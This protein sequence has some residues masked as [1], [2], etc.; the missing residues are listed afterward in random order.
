MTT[1]LAAGSPDAR[2]AGNLPA[3]VSS[4]IGRRQDLAEVKAALERSRLVTLCGVGGVG[5][6]RLALRTAADLGGRFADGVWLVELSALREPGPLARAVGDALRLPGGYSGDPLDLLADHLA[7]RHLLLVLDTCEH[8]IDACATLAEVLAR[9]APRLRI[10]V[11]SREPLDVIGEHTIMVSPLPAPAPAPEDAPTDAGADAGTDTGTGDSDGE[12]DGDAMRLF[13]ERAAAMKPGFALTPGNRRAVARLCHRLDGIPLAIELAA[14]RLRVMS[15]EQLD[16]RLDDRFRLLGTARTS[17]YRHQ[18]LH[19]AIAW[20]HELCTTAEQALWARLSVFPGDFDL[21]AAEHVCADAPVPPAD[22][23]PDGTVPDGTVPDATVL[24]PTA[25]DPTVPAHDLLDVLTRL[26]EKSVV[27]Y[28]RTR[29]RYRMLDT[30][31]EFGAELLE[32]SGGRDGHARRHHRHYAALS[33][34]AAEARLSGAQLGWARRLRAEVPNLRAA[35]EWT[36]NTP[37]EASSGLRLAA[38]LRHYWYSTGQFNEGRDWCQRVLAATTGVTAER[39]WTAYGVGLFAVLQGDLADAGPLLAEAAEA[40]GTLGDADLWAHAVHERGRS[41]FYAGDIEKALGCYRE[42]QAI[43]ERD[44]HRDPDALTIYTDLG[45][46]LAL[47]GDLDGALRACEQGL[48]ACEATGEQWARA[49]ALWMRG[50]TH[51]LGGAIDAAARDARESLLIVEAFND[52]V[53]ATM[54]L[55]LLMV[56][57]V[58]RDEYER[59]AVLAGA[60]AGMWQALRAPIQRGPHYAGLRDAG[61]DAARAALGDERLRTAQDA[62]RALPVGEAIALALDPA[63][64][65]DLP[66]PPGSAVTV[67]TRRERQVAELVAE[68]LSNREIAERLIIAKRTVDSHVEHILAKL[69]VSS[70][71]QVATRTGRPART[72]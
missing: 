68:G 31:R 5:K 44:G 36:L 64:A 16:Q 66:P 17:Q 38:S 52:Q 20:S 34:R 35:L 54:C 19:A 43:Y 62:G 46:A 33:E 50:A 27:R 30:I 12:A 70:R 40:A 47:L 14:V 41:A 72:S 26:V 23:A 15:I 7:D 22:D 18:T 65:P 55:D 63:R 9:A 11:T 13:A 42:T 57:A 59:A 58:S 53:A 69:G 51:Y 8:L 45:S 67:L 4:F 60:T 56:C 29:G 48:A 39:G 25:L 24:D 2:P 21:E 71:T 1:S 28:E 61:V 32:Q 10:I 3:E 49:F 37:G 6:T